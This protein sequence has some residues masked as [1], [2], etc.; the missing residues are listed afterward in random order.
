MS[1]KQI[2]LNKYATIAQLVEQGTENPCVLGSIPSCG[3]FF[4]GHD[5]NM[6]NIILANNGQ[7]IEIITALAEEI[8][9]E[10]YSSILSQKQINYM[11]DKFQSFDAITGQIKEGY[12]YYL[13]QIDGHHAGYF[14]FK[15]E[16]DYLFLSKIYIKS[17]FRGKG[18]ARKVMGFIAENA[19]IENLNKIRLTV[20]KNNPNSIQ[21]YQKMGFR[22]IDSVINDIGE[23][24]VMDDFVMEKTL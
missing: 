12:K 21:T 13:M 16:K 10:H 24:F 22:T 7:S 8:W 2:K 4:I 3:I 14:S 6:K 9:N 23:G 5:L 1:I 11:L 17:D 19:Q 18:L 15:E 20:N